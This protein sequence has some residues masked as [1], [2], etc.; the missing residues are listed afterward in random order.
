MSAKFLNA[1][2]ELGYSE[3]PIKRGDQNMYTSM[4]KRFFFIYDMKNES[5]MDFFFMCYIH[6][7]LNHGGNYF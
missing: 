5:M 4:E 6:E 1:D 2:P 3:L 7:K